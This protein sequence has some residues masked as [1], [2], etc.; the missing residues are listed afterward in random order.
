MD[1]L[2]NTHEIEIKQ[3]FWIGGSITFV[4][5]NFY[6]GLTEVNLCYKVSTL[7]ILVVTFHKYLS[8]YYAS[9]N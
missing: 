1:H 9:I 3:S 8:M 6:L 7:N 4:T 2:E 5:V